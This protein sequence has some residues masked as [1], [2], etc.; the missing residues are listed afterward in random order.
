MFLR[1]V[2]DYTTK[3]RPFFDLPKGIENIFKKSHHNK[4]MGLNGGGGGTRTLVQSI[5]SD[6]DYTFR[7]RFFI[8]SEI[9]KFSHR[10]ATV[11]VL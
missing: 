10:S 2:N 11:V 4:M 6:K 7:S 9:S 1:L 5:L 8:P 3:I